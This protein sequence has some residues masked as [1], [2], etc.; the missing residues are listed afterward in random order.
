MV[1]LTIIHCKPLGDFLLLVPIALGSVGREVC[2]LERRLGKNPI[3]AKT[4]EVAWSFGCCAITRQL[5]QFIMRRYDCCYTMGVE[6]SVF[7]IC[8]I[9]EA[10]FGTLIPKFNCERM[11]INHGL[12]RSWSPAAHQE[13]KPGWRAPHQV[14]N[15]DSRRAEWGWGNMKWV[16]W[17]V[18]ASIPVVAVETVVC[19]SDPS[20]V[21][22]LSRYCDQAPF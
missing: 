4:L 13:W 22:F 15:V 17:L 10:S 14:S 20:L 7:G 5:I 16:V 2:F 1:P 21:I 8:G 9:H 19:A 3:K 12:R 6:R 18:S 11:I